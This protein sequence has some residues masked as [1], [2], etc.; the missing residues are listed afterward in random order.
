[1]RGYARITPDSETGNI[2]KSN[3]EPCN[4]WQLPEAYEWVRVCAKAVDK[5]KTGFVEKLLPGVN[6]S[7]AWAASSLKIATEE[8]LRLFA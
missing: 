7:L 4:P 5:T 3:G 1:M 6:T 2:I 8:T